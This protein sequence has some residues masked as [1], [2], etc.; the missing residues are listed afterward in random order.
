MFCTNYNRIFAK[1]Y[2]FKY[3]SSSKLSWEEKNWRCHYSRK[4]NLVNAL[5]FRKNLKQSSITFQKTI[6]GTHC[7]L[8]VFL[9]KSWDNRQAS[10]WVC[11]MYI[12]HSQL[13]KA[14]P[15]VRGNCSIFQTTVLFELFYNQ[16][17]PLVY[18]LEKISSC[19]AE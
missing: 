1:I 14:R 2:Y 13:V 6:E 10:R 19:I 16:K 17:S 4:V 5:I 9:S 12:V 18:T 8:P 11:T 3:A 7:P 15:R